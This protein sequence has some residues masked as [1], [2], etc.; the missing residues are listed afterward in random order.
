LNSYFKENDI[1]THGIS[2]KEEYLKLKSIENNMGLHKK[3]DRAKKVGVNRFCQTR[4]NF[5]Y[6][7][8]S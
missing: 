6:K 8:D 1:L 2:R 5:N 4:F 7:S 3:I